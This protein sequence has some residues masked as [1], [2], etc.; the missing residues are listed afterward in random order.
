MPYRLGRERI[1]FQMTNISVALPLLLLLIIK[2]M[3][4]ITIVLADDFLLVSS[5]QK[6]KKKTLYC[7][8]LYIVH[9]VKRSE[10]IFSGFDME[11]IR[12][13]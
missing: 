1:M 4:I 10:I 5:K 6:K 2:I 11:K 9:H 12:E 3:M 13:N 7:F 8:Y